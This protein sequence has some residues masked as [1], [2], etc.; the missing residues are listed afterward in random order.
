MPDIYWRSAAPVGRRPRIASAFAA[1]VLPFVMV[2][3]A[4]MSLLVSTPSAAAAAAD[5]SASTHAATGAAAGARTLVVCAPGY[6][7]TTEEAQPTMDAFA[8]AAEAAAG[9]PAG[10]LHAV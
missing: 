10:S 2:L 3:L 6:P 5:A 4:A 8:R 1:L 9:W 7:G